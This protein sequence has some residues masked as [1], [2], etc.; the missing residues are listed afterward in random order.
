[1]KVELFPF[2]QRALD[3][4]RLNT[5]EAMGGYHRTH[6]PQVVSFTAPK[7]VPEKQLL[8]HL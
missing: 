5:A 7:P 2:Q 4:L 6:T 1:M 3:A 8:W